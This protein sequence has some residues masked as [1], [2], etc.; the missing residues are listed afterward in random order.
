VSDDQ[1]LELYI[2]SI[3]SNTDKLSGKAVHDVAVNLVRNEAIFGEIMLK[4]F[5]PKHEGFMAEAA[6]HK[7]PFDDGTDVVASV[8]IP[9]IHKPGESDPF[10]AKY[11]EFVAKGT[12][13]F[14]DTPHDIFAKKYP[15]F[16]YIPP[17]RGAPGFLFKS[18]GQVGKPFLQATYVSMVEAMKIN[19][20]I[21]KSEL[22]ARMKSDTLS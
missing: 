9:E 3:K 21:F 22:T 2:S 14:G 13:L 8:G 7:G 10:S 16:M 20:E 19:G 5:V 1:H 18:K 11:P 15:G 17:E 6:G 12:G 4:A